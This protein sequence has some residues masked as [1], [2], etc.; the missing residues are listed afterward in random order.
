MNLLNAVLGI[1]IVL[2]LPLSRFARAR[3]VPITIGALFSFLQLLILSLWML[4]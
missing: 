1:A 4:T 2:L 3:W